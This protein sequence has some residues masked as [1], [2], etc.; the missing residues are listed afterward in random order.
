MLPPSAYVAKAAVTRARSV[1]SSFRPGDAVAPGLRILFYHRVSSERDPLAVSPRNFRDQM[2]CLADSEFTVLD[3]TAALELLQAGTL[4]PHSLALTFDDGYRD[5][6][7]HAVPV[8]DRHGFTATDFIV[9]GAVDGTTRFSWY[10]HQPPLLS[11]RD[12]TALD[13]TSP[14]RFEA[15]SVSHPN[16]VH[17]D[18]RELANEVGTCRSALEQRLGRAVSIFCYPGGVFGERERLAVERAG[19]A[20]AVSCEPGCND[21][22]ADPLLLL[23]TQVEAHDSLTDFRARLRGAHDTPLPAR[24]ALRRLRLGAS[25]VPV[26]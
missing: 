7:D 14:L 9:T 5:V 13:G 20:A 8:L 18:D 10:R 12:I 3:L 2:A 15:H 23:R 17:C 6:L 1:L 4:P 19:Y 25:R 16:L 21:R 11:W 22:D 24:A 26:P